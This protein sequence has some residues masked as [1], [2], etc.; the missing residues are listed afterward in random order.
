MNTTPKRFTATNDVTGALIKS[1]ADGQN[2]Y[3]DGWSRI[4]GNKE[5]EKV[6]IITFPIA[7][8]LSD[9]DLTEISNMFG[10]VTF[11]PED[12]MRSGLTR[13]FVKMYY[14]N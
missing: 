7:L 11:T 12:V 5:Q 4:F 3:A 13:A 1:R 6:E 14:N 9:A 10:V 8:Y 2:A